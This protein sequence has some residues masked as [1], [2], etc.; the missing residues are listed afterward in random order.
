[1][2]A[3]YPNGT[4]ATLVHDVKLRG[5]GVLRKGATAE[6]IGRETV[7]YAGEDMDPHYFVLMVD[8]RP[9]YVG[10]KFGT[11]VDVTALAADVPAGALVPLDVA[12]AD[13]RARH[14]ALVAGVAAKKAAER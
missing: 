9:G 2:D 12:R 5:F 14:A 8:D 4:V 6:V 3:L 13:G 10:Q 7:N 1:M 11:F